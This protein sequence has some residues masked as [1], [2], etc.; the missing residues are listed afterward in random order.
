LSFDVAASLR[1][2]QPQRTAFSLKHH[3]DT[4]LLFVTDSLGPGPELL[5]DTCVYID[6]LQG[7]TPAEVDRLLT[8]RTVNHSSVAL[9]ELT[10]FFGRLDPRHPETK[11]SLESL[12]GT[13]NDIP[14]HRLT[15]PSIR[16]CGEAGMLAGLTARITGRAHGPDLLNDTALLLQAGETGT[17]LLTRNIRDFDPL[18]QLA[19]WTR[20]LVYRPV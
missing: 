5:L 17:V 19:P 14:P 12:R 6:S 16:A 13:L 15:A 18:Q 10:H 7:R 20:V 9:A 8:L 11:A 4:E 3:R 2:L 1:R